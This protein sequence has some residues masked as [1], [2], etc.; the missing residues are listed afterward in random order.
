MFGDQRLERVSV[1]SYW[2]CKVLLGY[3]VLCKGFLVISFGSY[4]QQSHY[5][6]QAGVGLIRGVA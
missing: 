6:L 3:V 5:L 1:K 2:L 4:P